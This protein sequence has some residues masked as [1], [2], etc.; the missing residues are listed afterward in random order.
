[1]GNHFD[2]RSVGIHVRPETREKR[3]GNSRPSCSHAGTNPESR[4]YQERGVTCQIL[5]HRDLDRP[6][7]VQKVEVKIPVYQEK[8]KPQVASVGISVRQE[9]DEKCS[10]C[11]PI[12][13]EDESTYINWF[14]ENSR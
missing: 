3:C 9:V 12:I 8:P 14:D 4:L 5:N 13:Q 6:L 2:Y 10:G 7:P 1:M 11:D